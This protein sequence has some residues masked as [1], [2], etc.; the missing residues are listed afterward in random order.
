ML[1]YVSCM[2]CMSVAHPH[3]HHPSTTTTRID[4]Q[5]NPPFIDTSCFYSPTTRCACLPPCSLHHTSR[6]G[7]VCMAWWGCSTPQHTHHSCTLHFCTS[8]SGIVLS[9][10]VSCCIMRRCMMLDTCSRGWGSSREV[11]GKEVCGKEVCL[12]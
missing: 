2:L 11:C 6:W 8:F 5:Q 4:S 3:H 9:W 12:W 7:I 10:T 1:V